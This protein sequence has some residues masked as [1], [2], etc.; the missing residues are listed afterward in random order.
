MI[1]KYSAEEIAT[2][3]S[4]GRP[5]RA[6]NGF[7]VCCPNPHHP[8]QTPS[9]KI[10]DTKGGYIG[11][12]CFSRCGQDEPKQAL[13]D[14]GYIPDW[15]AIKAKKTEKKLKRDE[16]ERLFI[17][18]W[19]YYDINGA[20]NLK[21]SR[22]D[23]FD[24]LGRFVD[25]DYVQ[26]TG[27]FKSP[28]KDSN[29]RPCPYNVQKLK[30]A[31]EGGAVV[32]DVEGE[33]CADQLILRGFTATT[34]P[35]GSNATEGYLLA[36]PFK[37]AKGAAFVVVLDDLDKPGLEYAL[38]KCWQYYKRDIP[39]KLIHLPGM[40]PRLDSK[41]RDIKDWFVIY[42][43][44]PEELRELVSEAPLWEPVGDEEE[45]ERK[46]EEEKKVIQ[47]FTEGQDRALTET[48][49]AEIFRK[50][51]GED[52][53]FVLDDQKIR[54]WDGMRFKED[55]RDN[56]SF[57]LVQD[58]NDKLLPAELNNKKLDADQKRRWLRSCL[59]KSTI[60]NTLAIVKN[61]SSILLEEL[62]Q[63]PDMLCVLNGVVNLKTGE[64]L[65]HGPITKAL[66]LTK[67]APFNY[68][69]G[70]KCPQFMEFQKR[71]WDGDEEMIA[72]NKRWRGLCLTG[73]VGE[74]KVRI[75]KG[76]GANGK[77][78][79][80]NLARRIGGDTAISVNSKMFMKQREGQE[81]QIH[82]YIQLVGKRAAFVGEIAQGAQ[83]DDARIKEVSGG[84]E[85]QYRV[86]FQTEPVSF[87]PQAKLEFRTNYKPGATTDDALWRRLMVVNYGVIF[88][89]EHQIKD[90]DQVLFHSEPDGIGSYFC[91]GALDH[92]DHGLLWPDRIIQ[93]S[94][95]YRAEEDLVWQFIAQ[96]C[97]KVE[98]RTTLANKIHQYFK[99][100]C[101]AEGY[102]KVISPKT[103]RK[104]LERL[105]YPADEND[106]TL[107][108]CL[109][110]KPTIQYKHE[111]DDH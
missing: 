71:I 75:N 50:H 8:D 104:E 76:K 52:L 98:G 72:F 53:L 105:G 90:Y 46:K 109:V 20:L 56:D 24:D 1:T 30:A 73:R 65:D 32:F 103:L 55:R 39:V 28:S 22:F 15:E 35:G 100:W 5:K 91:L 92:F 101:K 58:C 18:D 89:E 40:G 79:D 29:Y 27:S 83:L 97:D 62:D 17:K 47:L 110:M 66:K 106:P 111:E 3:L 95:K 19:L 10:W 86:F 61:R 88:K 57:I 68:K 34:T 37:Y 80:M 60:N 2:A 45:K 93:D 87:F 81:T 74:Q 4:S 78:V 33:E 7:M 48:F 77:S 54:L 31:A 63:D 108:R 38:F 102:D 36:E 67:L 12:K 94:Q 6:G 59:N 99:A 51:H 82:S 23:L 11:V 41:G 43:H 16:L 13:V 107:I 85:C 9:C 49:N 21:I 64:L 26:K 14:Q 69:P 25:K 42:N 96:W 44:T 70:L 84:D